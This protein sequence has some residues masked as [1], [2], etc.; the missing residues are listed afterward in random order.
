MI[1]KIYEMAKRNKARI[2][3]GA[4]TEKKGYFERAEE[5]AI[6]AIEKGYADV[7][8]VSQ[9]KS[10]LVETIVSDDPCLTLIELLMKGDVEGAVR[11]SLPASDTLSFLKKYYPKILRMALLGT[12][13]DRYF[14][15]AP[16][17][18]D[19][20]RT[21]L[22]KLEFV[23]FG[24]EIAKKIDIKPRVG[25][26]SGGRKQDLGRDERV[27]KTLMEGEYLA[28]ILKEK[29]DCKHYEILIEDAVKEANIIIVPDGITGNLIFRTLVLL[30]G[31]KGFGAPV[32]NIDRVFVD[33]SR[34][35]PNYENA[36]ALASAL[37][38]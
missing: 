17:G 22:E 3:L 33:T 5:K 26:I 2:A 24:A 10:R 8:L 21:P 30:G 9:K 29:V 37:K 15:L 11:G 12:P 16:V 36:V 35:S 1:Q 4:G 14:F 38:N 31:G 34:V 32:V 19:E 27:D 23:E 20:G 7:V 13:K 18:I 6:S 28:S 25:I